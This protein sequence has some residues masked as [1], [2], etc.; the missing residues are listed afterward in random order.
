MELSEEN[1]MLTKLEKG[2]SAPEESDVDV[3]VK[4]FICLWN[5]LTHLEENKAFK[6]ERVEGKKKIPD[7]K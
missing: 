6:L 4:N 2:D 7:I 3:L 1:K 5:Q